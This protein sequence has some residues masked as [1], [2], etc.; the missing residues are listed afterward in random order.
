MV[1]GLYEYRKK[2]NEFTLNERLLYELFFN[3][4]IF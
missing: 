1:V 2:N 3:N 4:A